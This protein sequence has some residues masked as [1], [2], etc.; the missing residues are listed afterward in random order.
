DFERDSDAYEEK[1][2]RLKCV[3]QSRRDC[4]HLIDR[5]L[6]DDTVDFDVFYGVSDNDRRF[7]DISHAREVVG[8]DPQDN[9]EEWD[10]PPE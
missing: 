3:W 10:A 5:C 6:Q 2:A 9:A 7:C 8:Y 1:V 4:A